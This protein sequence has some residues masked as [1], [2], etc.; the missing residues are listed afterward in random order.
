MRSLLFSDRHPPRLGKRLGAVL[1]RVYVVTFPMSA[2][3][4]RTN[5]SVATGEQLHPEFGS[6]LKIERRVDAMSRSLW[7]CRN[8]E[9]PVPHGAVPGRVT[10]ENGLI[11]DQ[12]VIAFRVYLDTRRVIVVCPD[13]AAERWFRGPM[14]V[15][16]H[17][18]K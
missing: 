9:C 12:S 13:C 11:L 14:V 15:S 5:V 8:R 6:D 17:D 3:A 1:L 2:V 4:Q 7:R 18:P 16:G 10:A